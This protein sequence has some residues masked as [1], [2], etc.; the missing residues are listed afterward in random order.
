MVFITLQSIGENEYGKTC[1]STI[2]YFFEALLD[3]FEAQFF[4]RASILHHITDTDKHV[5]PCI[6]DLTLLNDAFKQSVPCTH[7]SE[8]EDLALGVSLA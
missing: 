2:F 4:F 6:L 1:H 5:G 3:H 7:M 8:E